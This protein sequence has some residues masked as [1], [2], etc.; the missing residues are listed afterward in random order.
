MPIASGEDAVLPQLSICPR[1]THR[2][3]PPR[4][5]NAGPVHVAA[6]MDAYELILAIWFLAKTLYILQVGCLWPVNHVGTCRHFSS[7]SCTH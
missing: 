1:E 6:A 4:A 7:G 2:N 5:P 3:S